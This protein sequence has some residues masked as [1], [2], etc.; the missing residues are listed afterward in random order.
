MRR[1]AL[2]PDGVSG[3]GSEA[4]SASRAGVLHAGDFV[5]HAGARPAWEHHRKAG[6]CLR[7]RGG[8][9]KDSPYVRNSTQNAGKIC[10]RKGTWHVV[11][12]PSS[13]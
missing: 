7:H 2:F 3:K 12:L 10:H 11:L 6:K 5:A 9:I 8:I 1:V 4:R 13:A